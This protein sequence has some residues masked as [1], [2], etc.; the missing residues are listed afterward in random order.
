MTR[1][2]LPPGQRKEL[3]EARL[4]TLI[5]LVFVIGGAWGIS[6]GSVGLGLT[7][8]LFFG[9]CLLAGVLNWWSIS[10]ELRGK[11]NEATA[12]VFVVAM[13]GISVLLGLGCLG[14]FVVALA[15]WNA[16]G[17]ATTAKFPRAVVLVAGAVGTVLFIGG[18]IALLL[19]KGR[20]FGQKDP[21][22]QD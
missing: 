7:A 16:F 19:R 4:L 3:R 13:M 8:V 17:F 1:R 15:G 10:A 22:D 21:G 14:A 5:G 20:P 6:Q 18:P 2:R 12:K 11:D 9:A